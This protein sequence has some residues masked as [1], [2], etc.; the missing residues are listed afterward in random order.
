M[1]R[2]IL[3]HSWYVMENDNQLVIL[4]GGSISETVKADVD[5]FLEHL[6]LRT[7]IA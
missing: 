1:N 6:N 4:S 2:N 7:S 5:D 3:K